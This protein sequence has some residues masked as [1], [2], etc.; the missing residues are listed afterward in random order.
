MTFIANSRLHVGEDAALTLLDAAGHFLE[1]PGVQNF[2][3]TNIGT[4][5]PIGNDGAWWQITLSAEWHYFT[6]RS[7]TLP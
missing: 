4:P 6:D 2:W 3:F 7:S 1:A 5:I